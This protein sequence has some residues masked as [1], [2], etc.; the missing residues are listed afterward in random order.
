MNNIHC[1]VVLHKDDRDTTT[2]KPWL[3]KLVARMTRVT[4]TYCVDTLNTSKCPGRKEWRGR[5]FYLAPQD[6]IQFEIYDVFISGIFHLLFSGGHRHPE[7]QMW[8]NR[9]AERG[10]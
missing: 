3:L 6:G 10:K 1:R 8:E 2:E 7:A 9:H 4:S 5:R